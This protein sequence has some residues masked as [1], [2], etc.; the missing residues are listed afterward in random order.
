MT[1]LDQWPAETARNVTAALTAAAHELSALDARVEH[2]E[3]YELPDGGLRG[4]DRRQ[5]V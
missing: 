4:V 3:H 2:V 5:R 1:A